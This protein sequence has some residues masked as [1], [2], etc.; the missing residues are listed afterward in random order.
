MDI[1]MIVFYL[2]VF[3][4]GFFIISSIVMYVKEEVR[5]KCE[6]REKN[7]TIVILFIISVALIGII[8]VGSVLLSVLAMLVMSSM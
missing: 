8:V 2:I 7:K 3:L 4:I 6:G 5:A 1:A